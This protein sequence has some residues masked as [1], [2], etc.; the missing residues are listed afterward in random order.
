[1]VKRKINN[2][3]KKDNRGKLADKAGSTAKIV[4]KKNLKIGGKNK[5]LLKAIRGAGSLR[6]WP[7][8]FSG[9]FDKNRTKGKSLMLGRIE[10]GT[11]RHS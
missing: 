8:N 11:A 4:L 10:R 3:N 9:A 6:T 5:L 2:N 1:M 7:D